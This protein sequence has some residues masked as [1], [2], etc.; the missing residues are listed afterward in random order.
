[1]WD[2]CQVYSVCEGECQLYNMCGKA[3]KFTVYVWVI[4]PFLED[5]I[6]REGE[7]GGGGGEKPEINELGTPLHHRI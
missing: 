3:A 2:V 6:P 7:G 5:Q 1:V 4:Y